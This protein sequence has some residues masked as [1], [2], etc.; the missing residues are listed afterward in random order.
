MI[1]IRQGIRDEAESAREA[2]ERLW[3]ALVQTHDPAQ[4]CRILQA[5]VEAVQAKADLDRELKQMEGE[6]TC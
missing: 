1:D 5:L 3:K 6:K 4:Q 2:V